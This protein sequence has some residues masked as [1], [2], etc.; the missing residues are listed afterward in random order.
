MVQDFWR[1][2]YIHPTLIKAVGC[3][4]DLSEEEIRCVFDDILM[5]I[6]SNF[7]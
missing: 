2:V 5:I 4:T 1:S 6:E 7:C 3:V